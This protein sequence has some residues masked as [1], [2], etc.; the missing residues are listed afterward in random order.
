[1]T[2][3]ASV[4]APT[5]PD[6]WLTAYAGLSG[7]TTRTNIAQLDQALEPYRTTYPRLPTDDRA[8]VRQAYEELFPS[9][10]FSRSPLGASQARAVAYLALGPS[11][12]LGR[13]R[14]CGAPRRRGGHSRCDE[15]I[16]SMSRHSAWIHSTILSMGRTGSRRP[17]T[18]ELALLRAM[19]EYAREMVLNGSGCGCPASRND[20]E[21]LLTSTRE[22]LDVYEGSSM[23]AR[24]SLGDQRVQ[25]MARLSDSLERT[26]LRCLGG[27]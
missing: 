10:R 4:S 22:A 27:N 12:V 19:N 16:D 5:T 24:L 21:A 8:R 18:E 1:M 26:W 23:P 3:G 25:R 6:P 13:D 14:D 2:N 15:S 7:R 9:Q 11:E 17:R 20:S